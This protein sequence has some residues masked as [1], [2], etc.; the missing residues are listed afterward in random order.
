MQ[1]K[2]RRKKYSMK[3]KMYDSPK[4]DI[5]EFGAVSYTVEIIFCFEYLNEI[6]GVYFFEINLN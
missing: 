4:I 1:L 2:E 3:T 5:F 6:N